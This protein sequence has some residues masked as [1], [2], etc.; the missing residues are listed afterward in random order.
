MTGVGHNEVSKTHFPSGCM[1]K[2][3]KD[4]RKKLKSRKENE[5]AKRVEKERRKEQIDIVVDTLHVSRTR[6]IDEW[7]E[8]ST[9]FAEQ[10]FYEWMAT[11][12]DGCHLVLEIGCGNGNS[13]LSLARRNDVVV[14]VDENPECIKAAEAALK[15]AGIPVL[16][17]AREKVTVKGT[18]AYSV[19]YRSP[20]ITHFPAS[21]VVLLTGDLFGDLNLEPWLQKIG[22]FDAVVC[23]LI[24]THQYR[25]ANLSIARIKP[26]SA[27][28]YRLRVQNTTY[29]LADRILKYDGIIHTV[30][31]TEY[32]TDIEGLKAEDV[33]H[34]RAQA[35][36]TSLVVDPNS[37]SYMPYQQPNAGI[38]MV[39]TPP[40]SGRQLPENAQMA[41]SS[42]IAR[43]PANSQN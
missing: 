1:G 24:G 18:N 21:G 4:Q 11:F 20:Q 10:G 12:V 25:H 39:N 40:M 19:E 23:W 9:F 6:Y 37:P 28:D 42:I 16:T 2:P 17:V 29:E 36:V 13:T 7:T 38:Q 15:D 32:P 31:R 8:T 43:K 34:H 35:S 30:D 3:S 5:R 22:P 41:L 33:Q 14:S 26:S 27:G